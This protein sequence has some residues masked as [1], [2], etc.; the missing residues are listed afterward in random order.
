[1]GRTFGRI[2][3]FFESFRIRHGLPKL[4]KSVFGRGNAF[5]RTVADQRI[6]SEAS[7]TDD[8]ARDGEHFFSK[9]E[10][11]LSGNEASGFFARFGHEGTVGKACDQRVADGKMV[12]H[13]S[14]ARSK[15]RDDRPSRT[16]DRIEKLP[17]RA[18]II[19]V[20]SCPDE[21]ESGSSGRHCRGV[22]FG[23][24]SCCSAGDDGRTMADEGRNEAFGHFFPV[25][26]SLSRANDRN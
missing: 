12:R 15:S 25:R 16:Y 2:R 24:D 17:I 20:D 10:R 18:R 9:I 1:M 8:V 13:G 7:R 11:E 19:D 21:R 14:G 22:G 3:R 5:R 4:A 23:V 26:G 6:G